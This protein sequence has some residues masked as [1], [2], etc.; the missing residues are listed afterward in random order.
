LGSRLLHQLGQASQ[1]TAASTAAALI[2]VVFLLGALLSPRATPWLTA[3][4]AL[5]AAV[6][7]VMVFA[8][9]HTQARQQA[10]LQRKLDE[11]LRVPAPTPAW[12]T[13]RQQ[14]KTSC[15]PSG[16]A[17]T[18]SAPTPSTSTGPDRG[19]SDDRD[20]PAPPGVAP[21]DPRP[22]TPQERVMATDYD[23]HRPR[24]VDQPVEPAPQA[25]AGAQPDRAADPGRDVDPVEGE[26]ALAAVDPTDTELADPLVP[27]QFVSS[28]APAATSCSTTAASPTPSSGSAPTVPAEPRQAGGR[29]PRPAWGPEVF[30]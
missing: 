3:F 4:E 30:V 25:L 15:T 11:I 7:L 10:A 26:L 13:W 24:H 17:T 1:S 28:S 21:R 22:A 18:R 27:R 6:T 14:P 2:S 20:D 19:S 16:N 12:S 9:Q 23:A 8:L 5:A 29:P